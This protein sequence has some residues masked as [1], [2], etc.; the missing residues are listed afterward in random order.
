MGYSEGRLNK[1]MV[2]LSFFNLA[3]SKEKK[4]SNPLA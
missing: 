1:G 2:S 4:Y 3:P